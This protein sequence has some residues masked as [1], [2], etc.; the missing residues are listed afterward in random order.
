MWLEKLLLIS[1]IVTLYLFHDDVASYL[2]SQGAPNWLTFVAEW[3]ILP[4][5]LLILSELISRIIQ[6]IHSD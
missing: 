1:V 5:A 4:I 6:V 2:Q 3:G